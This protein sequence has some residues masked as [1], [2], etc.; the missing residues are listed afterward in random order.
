MH[1]CITQQVVLQENQVKIFLQASSIFLYT[2][3]ENDKFHNFVES[4]RKRLKE[5]KLRLTLEY[6]YHLGNLRWQMSKPNTYIQVHTYWISHKQQM[7]PI[8]INVTIQIFRETTKKKSKK[9]NDL[10]FIYLL[11]QKVERYMIGRPFHLHIV[12]QQLFRHDLNC[13]RV[14][15][16]SKIW[17]RTFKSFFLWVVPS[18]RTI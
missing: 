5:R 9:Q 12:A 15:T 6:S 7:G 16:T 18:T 4:G 17:G 10:I 11:Q 13:V 14:F 1:L 2:D 8:T 3:F